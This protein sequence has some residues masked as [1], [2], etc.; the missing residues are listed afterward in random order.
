MIK[1]PGI[2]VGQTWLNPTFVTRKQCGH[3]KATVSPILNF[4]TCKA[5]LPTAQGIVK[6]SEMACEGGMTCHVCYV[7]A[8]QLS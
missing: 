1:N 3:E 8:T 5:K 6:N 7:I 2:G 4:L